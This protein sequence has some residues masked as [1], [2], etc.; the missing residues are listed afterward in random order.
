[1]TEATDW[2]QRALD[3]EAALREAEVRLARLEAAA[4]RYVDASKS[5][6]QRYLAEAKMI[7]EEQS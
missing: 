5:P 4:A 7:L 2:K 6:F 3:A 1:M